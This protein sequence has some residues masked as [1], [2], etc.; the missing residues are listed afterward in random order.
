[1]WFVACAGLNN[2]LARRFS[3]RYQYFCVIF[4]FMRSRRWPRILLRI[5]IAIIV[6][7]AILY[8][9][10]SWYV[11]SHE[12]RIIATITE[13]LKDQIAGNLKIDGVSISL[14]RDFPQVS[15]V[16]NE[17][18]L[19][20]SLYEKHKKPLL[21]FDEVRVEVSPFSL[22]SGKLRIRKFHF[23]D[24]F[25]DLFV[26]S[27]GYTN[28][29]A[30]FLKESTDASPGDVLPKIEITDVTLSYRDANKGKLFKV[31]INEL[32]AK[33]AE[34]KNERRIILQTVAKVEECNFN[35]AKGSFLK[36]KTLSGRIQMN[37]SLGDKKLSIL[38]NTTKID[39]V[40]MQW[41]GY[42][43]L[44]EDPV[45]FNIELN[46]QHVML[47]EVVSMLTPAISSNF[48]FIKVHKPVDLSAFIKGKMQYRDTP[49]VLVNWVV[50]NND[51][52]TPFGKMD[53]TTFEGY[54]SNCVKKGEGH[55]DRN[56]I[57]VLKN[58]KATWLLIPFRSD[59]IKVYDLIQPYIECNLNAAFA[60]RL[61]NPII[62]GES[63]L[64]DKGK[65][66][67]D[68]NYKGRIK[69]KDNIV[70][71][72]NG[73]LSLE[74][75]S[76]KYLPRNLVFKKCNALLQFRGADIIMKNVLAQTN[77]STIMMD[78]V[79]KDFFNQFNQSP[80]S[81]NI[82]WNVKSDYIDFKD[83]SSFLQPRKRKN[84][85]V[86]N[87]SKVARNLD[88]VLDAST[89]DLNIKVGKLDYRKFTAKNI[90]ADITLKSKE[91][92]LEQ[93]VLSQSG[94]EILVSGNLKQ[95]DSI[96]NKFGITARVSN[97]N[98]QE[99]FYS[100]ENF[101][102]KALSSENIRGVFSANAS[103]GGLL[104]AKGKIVPNSMTGVMD[105]EL[106]DGALVHFKPLEKVGKIVFK[107]R[108]LANV[109]FK[110]ISNTLTID[111][112]RLI[113]APMLIESSA[114]N[115]KV[116]GIYGFDKGTDI[117]MEIPM[118]NPNK[119]E[120]KRS[121]SGRLSNKKGL[122]LY[123]KAIEDSTGNVKITWDKTKQRR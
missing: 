6:M 7:V 12:K 86:K 76:L 72:I 47:H 64:L 49:D 69:H 59:S 87:S 120:V 55:T 96:T 90:S 9:S 19:R 73:Y 62:G 70:P 32:T 81:I 115:I 40:P 33:F 53:K 16:L 28:M 108:N 91:T 94:G 37:Y 116:S 39:K 105:F 29:P 11:S 71:S 104:Q 24:G 13:K 80:D 48:S 25:V 61:L 30:L 2:N 109:T 82:K 41:R 63:F 101:G 98:V 34:R 56:S 51:L 99:L 88:K 103:V 74:N 66:M 3:F 5:A 106:K 43:M 27:T 68:V 107:K 60:A 78:G 18:L 84:S 45:K 46:G 1:M 123:L 77:N 17:V 113:I 117:S 57:V 89:V 122:I 83:Y 52:M 114:L 121:E 119:D 10:V 93:I 100:F 118:R 20:D 14:L 50:K 112:G 65:V 23:V 75:V 67:L 4:C 79:A 102:L 42:F 85:P 35:I 44:G 21:Q 36:N 8:A 95:Q 15:V 110:N 92:N 97:V 22:L 58:V 38:R 26:D 31:D 111:K 54:Y